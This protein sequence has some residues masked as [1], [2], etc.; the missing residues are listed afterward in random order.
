MQHFHLHL[1]H[2]VEE[3][4]VCVCDEYGGVIAVRLKFTGCKVY[5]MLMLTGKNTCATLEI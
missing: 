2:V 5:I 3:C 1:T 4:A